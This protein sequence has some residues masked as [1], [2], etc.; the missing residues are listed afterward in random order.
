MVLEKSVVC[1]NPLDHFGVDFD[2]RL[3]VAIHEHICLSERHG[4]GEKEREE[5]NFL[6]DG[7]IRMASK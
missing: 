2:H 1:Q 6:K 3:N 7:N 4:K 5:G